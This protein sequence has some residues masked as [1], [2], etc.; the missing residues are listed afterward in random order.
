M[1]TSRQQQSKQKKQVMPKGIPEGPRGQGRGLMTVLGTIPDLVLAGT[2][3]VSWV[4]PGAFGV[5]RVGGLM[6]V[7]LFEFLSVHASAFMGN[8]MA[9]DAARGLKAVVITGLALFYTLFSGAFALA[10]R[11]WWP[12]LAL[13]GLTAEKL[14]VVLFGQVPD[15]A[16]Q[17]VLRMRW[18]TSVFWYVMLALGTSFLPIPALGITPSVQAEMGL[19]GSGLWVDEPQRVLAFGFLYFTATSLTTILGRPRLFED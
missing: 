17:Q 19:P 9:S 10:F 11:S 6:L 18:A 4:A 8:I 15:E 16:Q 12:L 5:E 7:M 2:F 3:L 1:T 13:W 14:G